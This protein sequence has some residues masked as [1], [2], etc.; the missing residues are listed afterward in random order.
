MTTWCSPVER[1]K[2]RKAHTCAI[3]RQGIRPGTTY[4][5]WAFFMDGSVSTMKAHE[6]CMAVLLAY[7][8]DDVLGPGI[9]EVSDEALSEAIRWHGLTREDCYS[10]GGE[11]GATAWDAVHGFPEDE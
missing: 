3:C 2:A 4:Q 9:F 7:P 6:G 10:A 5:R 8:L 1:P 11:E